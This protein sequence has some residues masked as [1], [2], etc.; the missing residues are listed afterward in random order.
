MQSGK[1]ATI[2]CTY[3]ESV[4]PNNNCKLI[5]TD[6]QEDI[7]ALFIKLLRRA[8]WRVIPEKWEKGLLKVRYCYSVVSR[9]VDS[10]HRTWTRVR[11]KSRLF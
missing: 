4:I 11:L 5:C 8:G 7:Q 9:V 6:N 3:T 10:S 1:D 2:A